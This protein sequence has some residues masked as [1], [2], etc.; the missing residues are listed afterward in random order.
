MATLK[1][2][3]SDNTW[4]TIATPSDF[5]VQIPVEIVD[6]DL[7][8]LSVTQNGTYNPSPHDGYSSVTV[9]VPTGPAVQTKSGTCTTNYNGA[10]TV[11][12]IGFKPDLVVFHFASFP[13]SGTTYYQEMGFPLISQSTTSTKQ[14]L[15]TIVTPEDNVLSWNLAMYATTSGFTLGALYADMAGGSHVLANKTFNYTAYKWTE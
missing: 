4:E 7:T 5:P 1:R 14:V 3:K 8:A 13:I 10:V 2:K 11:S 9:N 15:E 6:A 12:T